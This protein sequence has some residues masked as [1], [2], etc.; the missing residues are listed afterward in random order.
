MKCH[1]KT[2]AGDFGFRGSKLVFIH[3][4]DLEFTSFPTELRITLRKLLIVFDN[5]RV[6]NDSTLFLYA[7]TRNPYTVTSTMYVM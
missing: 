4:K 6:I 1:E 7:R 3:S 5:S 2:F